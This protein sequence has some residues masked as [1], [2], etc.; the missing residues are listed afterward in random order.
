MASYFSNLLTT[1]TSRVAS[2]RQ[3]LLPS[4]NDGDTE[5]DTHLCRVLRAYYTEK[6]RPF[7]G[8]LP[9]DPKAPPSVVVQPVYTTNVGARYGGLQNQGAGGSGSLSSLW[10]SQPQQQQQEPPIGL[11]QGRGG[12]LG[13]GGGAAA[14]QNP[15][16]RQANNPEPQ[17]QARP[18]PSQRAGSYQTASA[19][20]G[21]GQ[22][23]PGSSSGLSA[24]DRLKKN[25]RGERAASPAMGG[26]SASMADPQVQRS[27]SYGNSGGG[28]NYEDRFMPQG[29][30]GGPSGGGDKPFM[31]ATSPWASSEAEFGGG[32]Y[33]YSSG[34]G[35]SRQGLPSGPAA[36]R[37]GPGLP[38][39]P[40]GMR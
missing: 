27:N 8:W 13:P 22:T 6:G 25:F 30:V 28:G 32:G 34:G 23:P 20:G 38:S 39:G 40:R 4:E 5:D 16:A 3:N 9:P 36:G 21:Q 26:T 29:A 12:R 7:P 11:R 24:K 31:A 14:R 18:L 37:R 19:F 1:T 10:D 17:I 35:S 2:I 33:G 15:F